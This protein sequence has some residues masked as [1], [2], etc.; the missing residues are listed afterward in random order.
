MVQFVL[1]N[2]QVAV[3]NWR[4]QMRPMPFAQVKSMDDLMEL[5]DETLDTSCVFFGRT[6]LGRL[7]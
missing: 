7:L 5:V 2:P 6:F 4:S 1:S 3:C